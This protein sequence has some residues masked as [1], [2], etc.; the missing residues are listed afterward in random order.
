MCR[1]IRVFQ[2]GYRLIDIQLCFYAI[3]R[4]IW[5]YLQTVTG[6][7]WIFIFSGSMLYTLDMIENNE[8]YSNI[9]LTIFSAHETL[10]MIGYRN[11]PPNGVYTRLW[12]IIS[13]YLMSPIAQIILWFFQTK[14]TIQWKNLSN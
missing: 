9:R 11:N 7:F 12:T 5:T 4:C 10:Y 1:T 2:L 8:Q 6:L 3:T 13:I 14:V